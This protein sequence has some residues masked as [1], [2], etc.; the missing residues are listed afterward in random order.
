MLWR[1]IKNKNNADQKD[2]AKNHE[3]RAKNPENQR[4]GE[5]EGAHSQIKMV[6]THIQ[7]FF[8]H[9][10]KLVRILLPGFRAQHKGHMRVEPER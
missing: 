2:S 8:C 3:L 9:A 10:A 5:I 1:F 7:V 6:C 4:H